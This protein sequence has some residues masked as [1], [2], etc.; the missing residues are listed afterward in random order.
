MQKSIARL[1]ICALSLMNVSA[2]LTLLAFNT[3]PVSFSVPVFRLSS[4]LTKHLRTQLN[5]RKD[6]F[7][8]QVSGFSQSL[9][10]FEPVARERAVMVL[11]EGRNLLISM[12]PRSSE[13]RLELP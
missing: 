7:W 5:K 4:T 1:L 12:W 13:G 6:E 9:V 8:L 3:F 11:Y 2:T 10:A